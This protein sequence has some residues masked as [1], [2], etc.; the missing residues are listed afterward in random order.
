M[1]REAAQALALRRPAAQG[2]HVGLDPGLV[3]EDQASRIEAGLQDVPVPSLV[4][5]VGPGL[6]KSEQCFF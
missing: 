6:L 5:H 3:D 4:S 1:G 2:S